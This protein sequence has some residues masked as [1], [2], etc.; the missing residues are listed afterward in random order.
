MPLKHV[1]IFNPTHSEITA[2]KFRSSLVSQSVVRR[3]LQKEV[4][5]GQLWLVCALVLY[6]L[7]RVCDLLTEVL[8][9]RYCRT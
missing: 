2:V 3:V 7:V 5:C 1:T 4:G 8:A 6:V 9:V